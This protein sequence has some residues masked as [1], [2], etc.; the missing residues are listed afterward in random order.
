MPILSMGTNITDEVESALNLTTPVD[1]TTQEGAL[2]ERIVRAAESFVKKETGRQFERVTIVGET[3]DIAPGTQDLLLSD[4]PI[5]S[6]ESIG[7]VWSRNSDGSTTVD[8]LTSDEY[9]INSE[10]GIVSLVSGNFTPGRQN[11]V[12]DWTVGYTPQEIAT[13][14]DDE[15]RILKQLCL[16]IIQNWYNKNKIGTQAA[17]ISFGDESATLT[18]GLTDDEKRLLNLLR[19]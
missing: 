4:R 5:V 17:T 13:N 18:F 14:A 8:V 6:I 11:I 12:L 9:L 19:L 3:Y 7:E 2:I 15:I 1:N 16:S 10:S